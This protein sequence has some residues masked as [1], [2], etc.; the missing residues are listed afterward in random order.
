MP[1]PHPLTYAEVTA[2]P[3]GALMEASNV[4]IRRGGA[5]SPLAPLYTGP[6]KVLARQA[7]FGD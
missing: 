3:A 6:Y 4:Y 5:I 2:K 1:A 7:K